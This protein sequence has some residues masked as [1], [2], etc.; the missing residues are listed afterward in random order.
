[1]VRFS[2]SA[3]PPQ[4]FGGDAGCGLHRASDHGSPELADIAS[5]RLGRPVE[6]MLFDEH[7]AYD[8]VWASA[9][10]LHVPRDEL[11]G[12]LPRVHREH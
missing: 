4:S 11:A 6:A 1:V 5:H 3:A 9:S 2:N 10:L 8:G 12:I 7:E